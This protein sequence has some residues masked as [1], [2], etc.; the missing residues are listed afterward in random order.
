MIVFNGFLSCFSS[1][2][3]DNFSVT[4]EDL[5]FSLFGSAAGSSETSSQPGT[6]VLSTSTHENRDFL[7]IFFGL[8]RNFWRLRW[9]DIFSFFFQTP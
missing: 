4:V 1:S 2:F 8:R 6:S 7:V 9:I 5:T 3:S